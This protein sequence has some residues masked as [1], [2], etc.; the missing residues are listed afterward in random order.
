MKELDF[1]GHKVSALG[2]KTQEHKIKAISDYPVP[3]NV[4][5]LRRFLGIIGYYRAFVRNYATIAHPLTSLLKAGIEFQWGEKQDVAFQNLK[6][7]LIDSPILTYPDFSKEFFVACDASDVGLGAVLLQRGD[8]KLMPLSFASRVL[9]Q[10]ERNYSVTERELLAVVWAMRKFRH[11]ILGFP[12]HVITDH[13]PVVDLFKKRAFVLNS[14]FNRWFLNILEYNPQFKYLP[15]RYNT[16]A[17]GLSRVFED[18]EQG[19]SK[20]VVSFL[21]QTVDLDMDLVRN[22]QLQDP[23]LVTV[24]ENLKLN[25]RNDY[26]LL[27]GLLYLKPLKEGGCARLYVPKSLRDKV[28]CLVH[29]H[30]LSGH[31]G[32]AKTI[33]HLSRN[34]FWP[35][36]CSDVRNFVLNCP[37]CQLNKGNKNKPAPLEI[38]PSQLLPFHTVSMDILGPLPMTDDGYKYVLVFVDFLSR[39][40]EIVPIK[41]RT[42]VSVAEALRHRVITRH[43]CPRVLISDNAKEFV[44]EIFKT[45]CKFYDIHKCE[46]VAHKPSSNGL[47]ERT[48]RKIIEVLRTLITPTT[49]DWHLILDDVQLTLNNTVNESVGDS[50]HYILYG[51][52]YRMPYA[53]TEGA[54]PPRLTYNYDDYVGYRTRRSYEIVKKVREELQKSSQLRKVRYDKGTVNPS[55][56]LGQKVYVVKPF[57]DGP[58]FKASPK[59]EGPY[60]VIEL[61]KFHKY[62]L[63]HIFSGQERVC[64]WNN[65]KVIKHDIDVSFIRNDDANVNENPVLPQEDE[66]DGVIY[67]L[68]SHT[69]VGGDS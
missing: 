35:K 46:I 4:K 33:K 55:V 40:S 34:F 29:S 8:K 20:K 52:D 16:I 62:K 1:L 47:V 13:L 50:P 2:I 49:S 36:S 17:D 31:P 26:Q 7:K 53:L 25:K 64:H 9:T 22:E 10:T 44:S 12:V 43:S 37:T 59:F 21:V 6:A 54:M 32:V 24:R 57:K 11:T 38:Y 69:V 63:R 41:D 45:L 51:Y 27:N 18:D 60:R 15:G 5:A 30:K 3:K 19:E 14:K 58:L 23:E 56:K 67:N 65:I 42:A 39:Y 28:L 66:Q 48:N 68:R 61:L